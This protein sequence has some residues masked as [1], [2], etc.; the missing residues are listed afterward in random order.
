[1]RSSNNRASTL[2]GGERQPLPA[3]PE[4]SQFEC[5]SARWQVLRESRGFT[6]RSHLLAS[7]SRW[8][9]RVQQLLDSRRLDTELDDGHGGLHPA[10][11]SMCSG[12]GVCQL[13]RFHPDTLHHPRVC[14]LGLM[15]GAYGVCPECSSQNVSSRRCRRVSTVG[16]GP[17]LGRSG[18]R[19]RRAGHWFPHRISRRRLWL[20]RTNRTSTTT[21]TRAPGTRNPQKAAQSEVGAGPGARTGPGRLGCVAAHGF[22]ERQD[23]GNDVLHI[24]AHLEGGGVAGSRC[25]AR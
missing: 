19:S 11:G 10:L 25:R 8:D 15:F 20:L 18:H 21:R 1:M 22:G 6:Y 14:G 4:P 12:Q 7:V 2:S 16:C 24:T 23:V 9:C 3:E 17:F 13:P 5:A